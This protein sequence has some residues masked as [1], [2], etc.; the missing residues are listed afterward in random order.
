MLNIQKSRRTSYF[1][2]VSKLNTIKDISTLM[3]PVNP[4]IKEI[5]KVSSSSSSVSEDNNNNIMKGMMS[6]MTT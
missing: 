6:K 4:G 3:K 1:G 5:D 2:R